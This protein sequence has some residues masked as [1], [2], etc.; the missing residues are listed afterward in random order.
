MNRTQN[1]KVP[2]LST[3]TE[4]QIEK[5]SKMNKSLYKNSE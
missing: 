5:E 4:I 2:F 3:K 1:I